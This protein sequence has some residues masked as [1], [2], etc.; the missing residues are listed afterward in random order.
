MDFKRQPFRLKLNDDKEL[1]TQ[2][3][4][5][6]TGANAQYMGLVSDKNC[7]GGVFPGVPPAMV[8]FIAV[9]RWP[10]WAGATRPWKTRCF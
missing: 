8:P 5:I 9:S 6:A 4:I 7:W 2:A 1:E 3:V 10:W